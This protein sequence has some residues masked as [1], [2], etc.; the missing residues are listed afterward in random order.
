VGLKEIEKDLLR[1]KDDVLAHLRDEVDT[2]IP[3]DIH[4]YLSWIDG[5]GEDERAARPANPVL[6]AQK[7]K[8]KDD[9]ARNKMAKKSK[10]KNRK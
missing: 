8:K 3:T 6:K 5:F 2:R 1:E 10:K 7:N 4:E 9:R